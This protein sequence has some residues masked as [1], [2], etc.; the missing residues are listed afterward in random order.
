MTTVSFPSFFKVIDKLVNDLNLTILL[1][2]DN[3]FKLLLFCTPT[4]HV[5]Q[6]GL[7]QP[8]EPLLKYS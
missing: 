8:K 2:A 5:F 3:E 6:G 4:N 1:F 7:T